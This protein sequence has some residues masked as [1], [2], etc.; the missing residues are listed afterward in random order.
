MP[1]ASPASVPR[2]S[3]NAD[4]RFGGHGDEA[5]LN[6][7]MNNLVGN[8]LKFTNTGACTIRL[9]LVQIQKNSHIQIEVEDTGIGM[10]SE[11]VPHVF[12]TFRQEKHGN[13][14]KYEGSGLGLAITQKYINLLNGSIRLKSK[15]NEGSCF[16]ILL[17]YKNKN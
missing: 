1:S 9:S 12:D 2:T 11:F 10:S 3:P 6:Q 14:R 4:L 13:S 5:M 7:I 16:S 15:K 8:A 17:P